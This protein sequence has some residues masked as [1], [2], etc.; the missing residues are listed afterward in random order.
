LTD[1]RLFGKRGVALGGHDQ[2]LHAVAKLAEAL[3]GHQL[4]VARAG[5]VDRDVVQL[6]SRL[7]VERGERFV[8]QQDL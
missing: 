4:E 7:L 6:H 2:P 3:G 5:R 1:H 8:Q